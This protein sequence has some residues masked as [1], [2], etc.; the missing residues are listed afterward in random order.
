[1][2]QRFALEGRGALQCCLGVLGAR[3]HGDQNAA[4]SRNRYWGTPL[5]IWINDQTGNRI[6]IGSRE[7]LH[8]LTG[9]DLD[10]LHRENVDPLTFSI[11]GEEGTYRRIEDP[12]AFSRVCQRLSATCVLN[13]NSS[14]EYVAPKASQ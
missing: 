9:V 5:P 14:V 13:P 11:D 6:C 4:I 8:R 10:D 7:E 3:E 12:S 2:R 1:M